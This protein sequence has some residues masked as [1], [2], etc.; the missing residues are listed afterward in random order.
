MRGAKSTPCPACGPF[1]RCAARSPQT[2]N[3][4]QLTMSHLS[5]Y[6]VRDQ[7]LEKLTGKANPTILEQVAVLTSLASGQ[8][9][10]ATANDQSKRIAELEGRIAVLQAAAAKPAS[11]GLAVETLDQVRA[12]IV[13]E[14]DP[15]KRGQLAAQAL[16]LRNGGDASALAAARARVSA[17][18]AELATSKDPR[19]KGRIAAEKRA[20]AQ[21]FPL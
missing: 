1:K 14:T 18:D 6:E 3:V 16:F 2:V 13:A 21:K 15:A 8:T 19:A 10:V 4:Y 20:I 12:K 9:S 7:L 11:S 17:I 5:P